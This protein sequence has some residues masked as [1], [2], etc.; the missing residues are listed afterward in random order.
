MISVCPC[1][2][3][4]KTCHSYVFTL[5]NCRCFYSSTDVS[6]TDPLLIELLIAPDY[7]PYRTSFAVSHGCEILHSEFQRCCLCDS[8]WRVGFSKKGLASFRRDF[9]SRLPELCR[10][11]KREKWVSLLSPIRSRLILHAW[12][13]WRESKSEA[14]YGGRTSPGT[15][16]EGDHTSDTEPI[17]NVVGRLFYTVFQQRALILVRRY[18]TPRSHTGDSINDLPWLSWQTPSQKTNILTQSINT[19]GCLHGV[20]RSVSHCRQTLSAF[21]QFLICAVRKVSLWVQ[22]IPVAVTEQNEQT[23]FSSAAKQQL[24]PCWFS[25]VDQ[26]MLRSYQ[27]WTTDVVCARC[28]MEEG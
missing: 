20:L 26:E 12:H 11:T 9:E 14:S 10:I 3:T 25:L 4:S 2:C 17:Q 23:R 13:E 19:T 8:M 16:E 1:V 7:V 18:A 5:M 28:G 6:G 21:Q 22:P 27:S 15:K 24:K